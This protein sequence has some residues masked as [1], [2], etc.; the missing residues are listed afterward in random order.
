M[1]WTPVPLFP[2]H[3]MLVNS[4]SA[5]VSLIL[6]PDGTLNVDDNVYET[7]SFAALPAR[8]SGTTAKISATLG[9][10]YLGEKRRGTDPR[11]PPHFTDRYTTGGGP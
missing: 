8:L 1:G 9:L 10:R 6:F 7:T 4:L 11:S 3:R 2:C 5:W